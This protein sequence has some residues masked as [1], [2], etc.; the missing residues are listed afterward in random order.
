MHGAY[1]L[2]HPDSHPHVPPGSRH[3]LLHYVPGGLT[4]RYYGGPGLSPAPDMVSK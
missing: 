3:F 1:S 4:Y 2:R